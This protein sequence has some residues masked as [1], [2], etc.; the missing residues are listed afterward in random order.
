VARPTVAPPIVT[1]STFPLGKFR[2]SSALLKPFR[3]ALSLIVFTFLSFPGS[4]G[5][6]Q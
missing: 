5:L 2:T 1:S 3:S 6:S 4:F